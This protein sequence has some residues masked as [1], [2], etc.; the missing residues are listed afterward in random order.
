MQANF[1]GT[2]ADVAQIWCWLFD[3]AGVRLCEEYSRPDHPNR[4]F[5][6]QDDFEK[7]GGVSISSLAAWSPEFGPKPTPEKINFTSKTQH[8]MRAKGRTILR[9]PAFIRISRN[10]DQKGCLVASSISYWQERGARSK[11]VYPSEILDLIDWKKFE[12][13]SGAVVR[14]MRKTAPAKLGRYPIMP[15]AWAK[16]V[17]G[18]I[19][20]WNWG[21]ACGYPSDLVLP[22]PTG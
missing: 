14:R 10:G 6:T 16:L 19:Q 11:S 2:D 3:I 12:T 13:T 21:S 8:Q 17:T 18:E 20:L 15:D 1:F 4:W 9:S 7:A 5:E 22:R